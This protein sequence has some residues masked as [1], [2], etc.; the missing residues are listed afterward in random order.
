MEFSIKEFG[1][2]ARKRFAEDLVELL[3][4]MGH[5]PDWEVRLGLQTE[6]GTIEELQVRMTAHNRSLVRE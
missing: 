4:K 5:E 2:I 3:S 1:E 6:K